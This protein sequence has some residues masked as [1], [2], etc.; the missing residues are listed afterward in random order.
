MIMRVPKSAVLAAVA[1][2]LVTACG[3]GAAPGTTTPTGGSTPAAVPTGGPSTTLAPT[4]A[5]LATTSAATT[6]PTQAVTPAPV[7]TAGSL[8]LCSLLTADE[9]RAVFGGS[10]TEGVLTPTGGYCHWDNA[11]GGHDQVITAIENRTVDAIKSAAPSGKAITVSGHAAY[12]YRDEG[13]QVQTTFIDIGGR[14]LLLEFST[15][16]NPTVD[17][18]NAAKLADTAIGHM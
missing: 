4:A 12:T 3:S 7:E 9:I 18:L 6:A 17:E 5:P 10:W 15:S 11:R 2:S 1:L 13:A 14:S 8:D 16:S